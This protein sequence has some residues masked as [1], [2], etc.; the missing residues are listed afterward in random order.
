MITVVINGALHENIDPQARDEFGN[1]VYP[2]L[3][4]PVKLRQ[5]LIDALL[6]LQ[7]KRVREVLA[8]Y[9]YLDMGD[10]LDTANNTQ[11]PDNAEAVA[12]LNWY[13]AYYTEIDNQITVIQ[14]TPDADLINVDVKALEGQAYNT[15]INNAPLP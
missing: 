4:D 1:L 13:R 2:D 6:I 9:D 3:Q 7:N 15:A 10:L 14:N 11:D 12:I 5:G 8:K